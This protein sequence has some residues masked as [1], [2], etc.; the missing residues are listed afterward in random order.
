MYYMYAEHRRKGRDSMVQ[1]P[2]E[3][4][5]EWGVMSRRELWATPL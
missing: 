1:E 2:E 3:R 5:G 4:R